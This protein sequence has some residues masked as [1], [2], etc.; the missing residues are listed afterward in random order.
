MSP[1]ERPF[2]PSSF[3]FVHA[4]DL[5]LD[6][7][8][9]CRTGELRRQLQAAG[10][11]AFRALIDLCLA[12]RVHAL[13]LAGDV[14]DHD[15]LTLSTEGFLGDELT[16]V[17]QAGIT[18]VAISGNHDP[19]QEH[20]RARPIGWP[21]ER[22]TLVTTHETQQIDVTHGGELVGTIVA[23]GHRT[24]RDTE[25]LAQGYDVPQ[26]DVPAVAVLHTQVES[27][28][29]SAAHRPYAP[30]SVDDLAAREFDYW[31]LGHVHRRQ[32][33]LERP[34]AHYSGNLQG[35]HFAETGAKGAL[36]VEVASR[37]SVPEVTFRPL[38]PVRWERLALDDLDDAETLADL[39]ERVRQ[40]FDVVRAGSDVLDDQRWMLRVEL[41]GACPLAAELRREDELAER[42]ASELSRHGVLDVELRDVGVTV[43]VDLDVHRHQPHL[44]GEVLALCEAALEDDAL[45]ERL[46]PEHLAHS[47]LPGGTSDDALA[48][49][50][51]YL[52]SLLEGLDLSAAE[53]LLRPEGASR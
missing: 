18:V 36:V 39:T 35:R 24:H 26:V 29:E 20:D 49:K 2:V 50:R 37:G 34:T 43:P 53:L 47:D 11:A 23:S 10:R 44:L 51:D 25:N 13:V 27:A 28:H 8:Y 6:T 22:F 4:A 14:F 38:A 19:G 33:V 12:E 32:R 41:S 3:R 5:H 1:L 21:T 30:C 42:L 46:A 45:L 7:P 17:T 9:R 16:R 31:A 15:R 52:R 48:A 40:K